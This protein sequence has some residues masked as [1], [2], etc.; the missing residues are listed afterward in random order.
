MTEQ[1]TELVH[2]Q[3]ASSSLPSWPG[4][5][6]V[7]AKAEALLSR[8]GRPRAHKDKRGKW[9][10]DPPSADERAIVEAMNK[11]DEE[12]LKWLVSVHTKYWPER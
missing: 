6:A 7:Y 10:C 3:A 1:V 9:R 12:M 8:M 2:E 4:A 5:A 11:G